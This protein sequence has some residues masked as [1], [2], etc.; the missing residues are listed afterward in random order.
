MKFITEEELEKLRP[1][2]KF[3]WVQW[4]IRDLE[5]SDW[6]KQ[7]F[8]FQCLRCNSHYTYKKC[9]NCSNTDFE[10]TSS[11]G[12][13]CKKCGEGFTSWTCK[14]CG[15]KNPARNT[16]YVLRNQGCFIAT[17]VY[18]SPDAPEVELL[19]EFRDT[20]LLKYSLGKVFVKIYYFISPRIAKTI[21]TNTK[22]RNIIKKIIVIPLLGFANKIKGN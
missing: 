15:T 3:Q 10:S 9:S 12:I 17:A 6:K 13:F 19:R 18:G 16:R 8:V 21:S 7:P 22:L 1:K 5:T 20:W 14:N 4:E 11:L 2:N